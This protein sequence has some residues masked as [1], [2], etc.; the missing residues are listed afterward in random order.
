[1]SSE[2]LRR[3][4]QFTLFTQSVEDL[5][6][7]VEIT[8]TDGVLLYVNKAFERMYGYSAEASARQNA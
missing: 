4:P 6:H 1:M 2:R 3:Q 7:T 5:P 8:D